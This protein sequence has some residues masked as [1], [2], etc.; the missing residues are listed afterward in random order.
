MVVTPQFHRVHHS[1]EPEHQDRNFGVVLS[2]WDRIFGTM[3]R[4][5]DVYPATGVEGLSAEPPHRFA[6]AAW[7]RD[8]AVLFLHP[9]RQLAPRR[10]A[11]T[12]E[13][14]YPPSTLAASGPKSS[15]EVTP[16]AALPAAIRN[17]PAA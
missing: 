17:P 10:A 15:I 3:H 11:L 16:S 4:D 7:A 8:Y 5:Y 6:P 2:V 12:R 13:P 1:I 14:G 9:F